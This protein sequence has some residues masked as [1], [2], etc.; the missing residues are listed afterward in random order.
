MKPTKILYPSIQ[1][2]LKDLKVPEGF[3]KTVETKK[4]DWH[5][6]NVIK[7][8]LD[9][10]KI[11]IEMDCFNDRQYTFK[12]RKKVYGKRYMQVNGHTHFL[13][14]KGGVPMWYCYDQPGIGDS[15]YLSDYT[16]ESVNTIITEQLEKVAASIERL[17]TTTVIPGINRN[18]SKDALEDARKSFKK[19]KG[20]MSY[21]QGFG[22][23]Y[24]FT[25]KPQP[26]AYH[27]TPEQEAFFGHSPL[28]I[29]DQ[30]CD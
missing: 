30:D 19:G 12:G 22:T 3:T 16:D 15:F 17:K 9:S 8:T 20:Y 5:G 13:S 14:K 24:F 7:I 29:I 27:A 28:F 4:D 1:S 6:C 25:T 21:P 10:P 2:L 23:G 11:R 26:G 18:I